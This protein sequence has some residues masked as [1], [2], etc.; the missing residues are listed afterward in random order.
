MTYH[1]GNQLL[2]PY[3][4]FE[5]AHLQQ[6]MHIA[7]FGCGKTGHIIFP[8]A[9]VIGDKGIIYAVDILQET[10]AEVRRRAQLENLLNVHTVW[11]DLERVGYTAI[12]ERSLDVGFI[13]NCLYQSQDR[14]GMLTESLR[15][16]KEKAR[17]V[18]VD[19]EKRCGA[20]GPSD[21]QMVN[22]AEIKNWARGNNLFLQEEFK[23]GPYHKGLVFF[24]HD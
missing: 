2:D 19:W 17:L 9:K 24:R 12:P 15:L 3:L 7:D 6:G 5:K 8:A 13:I 22:F 1:S 14:I 4:L 18:I 10:L 16:L 23:A 20:L 11:A 21:E